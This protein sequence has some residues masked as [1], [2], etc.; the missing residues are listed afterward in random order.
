MVYTLQEEREKNEWELREAWAAHKFCNEM[1]GSDEQLPPPG[2][3]DPEMYAVWRK[4][5]DCP[6][7]PANLC[8][9]H[10]LNPATGQKEEVD[11]QEV[12]PLSKMGIYP[13]LVSGENNSNILTVPMWPVVVKTPLFFPFLCGE[14]CD[15]YMS[16]WDLMDYYYR[17]WRKLITV[18][19]MPD[20]IMKQMEAKRKQLCNAAL[21]VFKLMHYHLEQKH[22]GGDVVARLTCRTNWLA[23]G[24]MLHALE[25]FL[26]STLNVVIDQD[27]YYISPDPETYDVKV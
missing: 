5:E 18:L 21:G 10:Y 22:T 24:H 1:L 25:N 14:K 8:K 19:R 13:E 23:N 6:Y 16:S 15:P 17:A 2:W 7:F 27:H 3:R 9:P 11:V 12:L 4:R 26:L 20:Q